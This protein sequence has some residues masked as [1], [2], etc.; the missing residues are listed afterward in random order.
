MTKETENTEMK[1]VC[2]YCRYD[3]EKELNDEPDAWISEDGPYETECRCG[4]S[5]WVSTNFVY[6]FSTYKKREESK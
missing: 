5:F 1:I 3:H 2:P 6:L 4:N